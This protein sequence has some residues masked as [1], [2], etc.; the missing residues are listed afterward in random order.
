MKNHFFLLSFLCLF[1]I[2]QAQI[3]S[4]VLNQNPANQEPQPV[5]GSHHLME[6]IDHHQAGFMQAQD[7]WTAKFAQVTRQ[8][9]S[10]KRQETII[11]PVVFHVVYHDSIG[12]LPDSVIQNQLDIL[13]NAFGHSHADTSNVRSE[14]KSRVGN[15]HIEF[16]LATVDPNGNATTG[17]VRTK[18][19]IDYF[20]GTLP[21]GPSERT[22]IQQWVADSLY[23][24]LFRITHSEKGGSD[25]WDPS[26]YLNIWIGDLRLFEPQFNDS[27]ELV[28]MGLATPP[29]NHKNW[30]E[31]ELPKDLSS[32]GVLLHHV[33]VGS[34][35]D[36]DYPSPYDALND[37]AKQG[38][39]AVHEVGHYLGLRHIWGDG[40]DCTVDDFI[41]DTPLCRSQSNFACAKTKN[42][43][44]D[45]TNGPDLPDMV[46][47][48]MDYSS[49]ECAVAFTQE[50]IAMMRTVYEEYRKNPAGVHRQSPSLFTLYPN[51]STGLVNIQ[52]TQNVDCTISITTMDGRQHYHNQI[53]AGKQALQIRLSPGIYI[54][55]A[56]SIDG[57]QKRKLVIAQ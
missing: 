12:N 1:H 21:Y 45:T 26:A 17:I 10:Y 31:E 19:D 6:N 38:K 32:A 43:C 49:G 42:S 23:R 55:A 18:T 13:N 44:I 57:S 50:Q 33:A 9:S 16:E 4:N 20:G 37:A 28:F 25:E 5:C 3:V 48:Y 34:N 11:I 53:S 35:N 36:N 46:E 27:E 30:P 29:A 56:Q 41:D 22:A 7:A 47:N 24:N 54:V 39:I 52:S 15:A 14:F 40:A 8:H 2:G 51:P